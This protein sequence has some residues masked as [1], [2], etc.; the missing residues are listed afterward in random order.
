MSM[1]SRRRTL[2]LAGSAI[3]L[4]LRA[5]AAAEP[6]RVTLYKN[7]QCDCCEGYAD[8]LRQ[9]GF[10]VDV[11][12][13]NDLITMARDRGVPEALDGCHISMIEGYVVIGHVPID[14]VRKLLAQRPE[15]IGISIAGM[16]TGLPGMPGPRPAPIAIYE[17]AA[18]GGELKVFMMTS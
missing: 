2:F 13:T 8:Y 15:I 1:I 12:P 5:F 18:G 6:M 16:P 17:I 11:V 10:A 7:P 9:N 4:P 3:I 14:A